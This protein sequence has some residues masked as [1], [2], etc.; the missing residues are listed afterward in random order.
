[1]R[2]EQLTFTRFLAAISI[3]IFHYGL[4]VFP[5]NNG[6]VRFLFEQANV[7]VSYFFILSGFVM[8]VAYG[9]KE[10]ISGLDYLKNRFARVYPIYFLALVFF[11]FTRYLEE[12]RDREGFFLHVFAIQSWI[13]GKALTLN[14]PGWSLSVEFFFYLVFPWLYNFIYSKKANFNKCFV[15][16]SVIWLGSQFLTQWF[17]ASSFY[18]GYPSKS[19]D[20]LYYSPLMHIN[21]FLIGNLAGLYYMHKLKGKQWWLDVPVLLFV[22]LLFLALKYPNHLIYHNGLLAVIFI[23]LILL[24]SLNKGVLTTIFKNKVLVFL[25]EISF[26]IYILQLPVWRWLT[27][28]RLQ[29]YLHIS[30]PLAF[31]YI[32]LC[33]LIFLAGMS[34]VF[35]ETPLR[36]KIKDLKFQR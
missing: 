20:L 31:F 22:V 18:H 17:Q 1:M 35:I 9:N 21:E 19:H 27:D 7:G 16:I 15:S 36:K 29:N 14:V 8:M 32:R 26:G 25:G 11:M 4:D 5:F 12:N 33:A 3:V 24:I 13:P 34:F 10:R 23:P 2:I 30:D 28:L 6:Q